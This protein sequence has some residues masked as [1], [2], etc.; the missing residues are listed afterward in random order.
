VRPSSRWLAWAPWVSLAAF[1]V[2]WWKRW[3]TFPLFLDPYYHLLIARQVVDAGGPI[4]YEWW[5]CAPLGR[6]HLYPPVL[7]LVLAGL[8]KVGCDPVSALRLLSALLV[9]A[10]LVTLYVVLRRLLT[11]SVA[12]ASLWMALAPFSWILHVT[13]TLAS[14]V[15]LIE[16]LWL[17]VAVHERRSLA[18]SVLLG[19]LFYT[20]LGLPWVAL[21]TYVW[22]WVLKVFRGQRGPLRPVGYGLLLAA[23]WLG[24][25]LCHAHL[26][27]ITGRYENT[28]IEI[29]PALYLL[30]AF[31][32]W[33]CVKKAGPPRML[34][35]MWLGFSLMASPFLFRWLSGEGL[36][37][38][39]LLAG[40]GLEDV[41]RRLS[42]RGA[43]QRPPWV[44]LAVLSGLVM[45]AP[46]V[47]V[48]P[49]AP[50]AGYKTRVQCRWPDTTPFHLLNW[51]YVKRKAT[52][53]SLYTRLTERLAQTVEGV[54]HP[55]EIL[56]S[57]ATYT[58]GMVAVLAHRPMASAM[59]YETPATSAADP[60][61]GAHLIMWLKLGP[62]PGVMGFAQ[63]SRYPLMRVAEDDLAII[64]RNKGATQLAHPPEAVIPL[65]T[66]GGLLLVAVGF[67]VWDLRRPRHAAPSPV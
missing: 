57:N 62:M 54:S 13:G 60:V 51:P 9:P 5:E 7:H 63:L 43:C 48:S 38:V 26:L 27:R 32:A 22:C 14:G 17:V 8:L 61:A 56:W 65:W 49:A 53:L 55:G 64:F 1:I 6:P 50:L 29:L 52:D 11:P 10:L 21:A 33:R 34:L 46:S 3:A 41:S 40:Y 47:L 12:L 31:G 23:P 58:G 4:A 59:F 44:G 66:A 45:A 25:L 39:I 15:A 16:L 36:L 2:L 19:L 24:H 30:A 67:V 20:H 37:P 35:G 28:A 18:A 42:Q